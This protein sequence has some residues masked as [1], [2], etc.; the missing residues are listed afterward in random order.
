MIFLEDE[1]NS[2]KNRFVE[3]NQNL[4][5]TNFTFGNLNKVLS[6]NVVKTNLKNNGSVD[7]FSQI[8]AA[9]SAKVIY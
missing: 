8:N 1:F 9:V 5:F 4:N 3:R 2:I 6:N 7:G